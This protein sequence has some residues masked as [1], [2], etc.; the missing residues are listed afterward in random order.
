MAT[1]YNGML[2]IHSWNRW[3]I[4]L[5]GLI[6]LIM[7]I[8]SLLNNKPYLSRHKRL[9]LVFLSSLHFQLLIGLILYF[10][11]SPYVKLAFN[12]F[13]NAMKNA[14]LRYWAVEHTLLTIISIVLVQMGYTKVKRRLTDHKKLRTTLIWTGIAFVV[15]LIAI[16]VGLM[17]VERPWFRF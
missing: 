16:P 6:L 15:I 13:G 17:G 11:L 10:F 14:D 5:S 8:T 4:L 1:L 12:D 3:I 2:L 7:V 9:N